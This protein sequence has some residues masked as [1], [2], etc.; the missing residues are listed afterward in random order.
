MLWR[1]WDVL[2]VVST[3]TSCPLPEIYSPEY[4]ESHWYS[5]W[6]KMKF[7][8]PGSHSSTEDRKTF[9]MVIPPPNVTGRLHMGHALTAT[10][11]DIMVRWWVMLLLFWKRNTLYLNSNYNLNKIEFCSDVFLLNWLSALVAIELL[12][13]SL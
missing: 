7:F 1:Y 6:E 4:V 13:N 11:E 10:L 2:T 5:W 12:F 9:S 3:D 8:E